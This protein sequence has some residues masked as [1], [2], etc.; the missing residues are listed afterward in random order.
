MYAGTGPR[1]LVILLFEI[2]TTCVASRGI[3]PVLQ[4]AKLGQSFI[5]ARKERR[6]EGGKLPGL[7]SK[8]KDA[9][10]HLNLR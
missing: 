2:L 1:G 9:Q 4:I 8:M 7:A 10:T 5:K 6:E 3:K